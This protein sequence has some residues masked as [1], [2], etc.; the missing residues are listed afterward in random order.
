MNKTK[1]SIGVFL[2][3]LVGG[4]CRLAGNGNVSKT[5]D[6]KNLSPVAPRL[7]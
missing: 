4:F 6:E 7:L 3:F 2:V 1:L 5:S